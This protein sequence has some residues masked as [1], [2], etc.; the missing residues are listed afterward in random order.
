MLAETLRMSEQR[1]KEQERVSREF[2]KRKKRQAWEAQQRRAA[3][4]EW[5]MQ[6]E[7]RKEQ[8]LVQEQQNAVAIMKAKARKEAA[9]DVQRQKRR[10]ELREKGMVRRGTRVT[11]RHISRGCR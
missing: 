5:A 2:E 6:Q 11:L 3:A 4:M 10:A 1:A 8:E 7:T 9:L